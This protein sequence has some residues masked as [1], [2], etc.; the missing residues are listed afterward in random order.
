[1]VV[2][3]KR[4]N[5]LKKR[6]SRADKANMIPIVETER[7]KLR[8]P[9]AEDFLVYR[10]FFADA[11]ASAFYGGPLEAQ[12]AWRVMAA[13]LGH[14]QLRGYGRWSVI[15]KAT[16]HMV[17]GCGLWWPEGYPRPELTWWIVPSAR[18]LG[19][20]LEASRAAIA[21]GYDHLGW[22]LVE[23]HMNDANVAARKLVEKLCGIKLLRDRFPD[24][25][26]RD[27]FRLPRPL[28]P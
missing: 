4:E 16:G 20:A 10:D 21:F 14:W 11:E 9:T 15:E 13:D 25:L 28:L 17:G 18:R 12:R 6:P 22:P 27:V 3:P 24:G 5:E 2:V 7:L 8:G 19:Y 26:E 23:T 1:M